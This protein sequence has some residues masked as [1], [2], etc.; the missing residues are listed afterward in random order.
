MTK[1]SDSFTTSRRHAS[2]GRARE[3]GFTL[4]EAMIVISILLI[5]LM[6]AVPAMTGMIRRN[7]LQT[8]ADSIAEAL[9]T[10]RVEA[11]RRGQSIALSQTG[12][13]WTDGWNITIGGSTLYSDTPRGEVVI[14]LGTLSAN[15]ST[16]TLNTTINSVGFARDGTRSAPN[17]LTPVALVAC[18][19]DNPSGNP[20]KGVIVYP[21]GM[22]QVKSKADLVFATDPCL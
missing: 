8:S 21:N 9:R 4:I 1:I 13:G 20:Y 2:S 16:F 5:M 19:V 18:D 12:S 11:I 7:R 6:I 15:D 14:R 22:V 10:A 3:S 17:N